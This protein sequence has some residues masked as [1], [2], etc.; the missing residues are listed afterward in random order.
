MSARLT[1]GVIL[2]GMAAAMLTAGC[3]GAPSAPTGTSLPQA[4][5]PATATSTTSPFDAKTVWVV[6]VIDNYFMHTVADLLPQYAPGARV[7]YIDALST[8]V[9]F[10]LLKPDD[11][12]A[13][14]II[15]IGQCNESTPA[16][17]NN[18][19][20]SL[21]KGIPTSIVWI[22]LL[23]DVKVRWANIYKIPDV[24]GYEIAQQ[25]PDNRVQAEQMARDFMPLLVEQLAG[26]MAAK[27]SP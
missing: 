13:A 18:A 14:A 7:R 17:I 10:F 27:A 16:T 25:P 11:Y 1:R 5:A 19:Q 6:N 8:G 24:Q 22:G 12:P 21:E 23:R 9:P 2:L 26:Q 15:G 3:A 4:Q 20:Q